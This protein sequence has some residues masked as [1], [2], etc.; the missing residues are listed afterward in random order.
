VAPYHPLDGNPNTADDVRGNS[1][2]GKI[3]PDQADDAP[4]N[5][6]RIE[7]VRMTVGGEEKVYLFSCD[8]GGRLYVHE[9]QDI[10]THTDPEENLH[11]QLLVARWESPE[12][13]FDDL[14][15]NVFDVEVDHRGGETA[16]VYV[17]V[18]R[19][20]I[21]VLDF[22]PAASLPNDRLTEVERLQCPGQTSALHL[23]ETQDGSHHLLVSDYVGGIRIYGE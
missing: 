3:V 14:P 11:S 20:G 4:G 23:V 9:I 2:L 17:A 1:P 18:R 12:A 19:V 15:T 7:T 13:L 10:L 5:I 21:V 8:F 22:N 16:T 6:W